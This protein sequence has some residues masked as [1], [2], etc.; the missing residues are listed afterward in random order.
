M[1]LLYDTKR[2]NNACNALRE[3]EGPTLLSVRLFA[4]EDLDFT[5]AKMEI[6]GKE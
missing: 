6:L 3:C 4:H 2:T 5:V 1:I